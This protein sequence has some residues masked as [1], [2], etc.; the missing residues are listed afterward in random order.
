M[1]LELAAKTLCSSWL[2]R[3]GK[4]WALL[5]RFGERRVQRWSWAKGKAAQDHTVMG[6]AA[7]PGEGSQPT[8]VAHRVRPSQQ[9]QRDFPRADTEEP[10]FVPQ[11]AVSR[12][13]AGVCRAQGQLRD[14]R[15]SKT[16]ALPSNG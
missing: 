2:Q 12:R 10:P 16:K 5:G 7:Q 6:M 9:A 14:T 4:L 8:A 3:V 11:R 13:W 1:A 15:M